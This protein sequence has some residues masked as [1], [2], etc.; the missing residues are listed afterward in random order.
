MALV[1]AARLRPALVDATLSVNQELQGIQ[2][3]ADGSWSRCRWSLC[4][5]M[6]DGKSCCQ[7]ASA[8]H[9]CLMHDLAEAYRNMSNLPDSQ[10]WACWSA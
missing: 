1:T 3:C 5:Y 8:V 4:L 6:V 10:Q 9:Y 2:G 7:H